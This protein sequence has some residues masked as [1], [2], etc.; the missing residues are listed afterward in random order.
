M[1]KGSVELTNARKEEIIAA[2]ELLY[3]TKGF[4]DI[5]IQDIAKETSSR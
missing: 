4:K 1:P 5:T 3:Q 2:A